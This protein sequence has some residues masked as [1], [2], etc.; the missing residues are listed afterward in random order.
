MIN[1]ITRLFG[2]AC[3]VSLLLCAI[4]FG[5]GPAGIFCHQA[6]VDNSV[7]TVCFETIKFKGRGLTSIYRVELVEPLF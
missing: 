7:E 5:L 2:I 3:L 1:L 4:R 6:G